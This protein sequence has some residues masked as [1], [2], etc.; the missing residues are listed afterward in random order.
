MPPVSQA[1]V[2]KQ[3]ASGR[4]EPLYLIL[5]ADE[6]A[7]VSLA[8]AFLDLVDE[9]LRAFN[10]DRLYGG[11]T[12]AAAV[13]DAA[14]TLP[15][16]VPRRVVLL[17]HAERL[18]ERLEPKKEK[19]KEKERGATS[20]DRDT[21]EAYVKAPVDTACL[22][23]VAAALDGRRSLTKLLLSRMAVVACEGP[24]DAQEAERWVRDRVSQQGL[25]I[26]ARAARLVAARVGPD[27]GRLRSDVDRLVLYAFDKKAITSEDVLEVVGAPTLQDD[28]G[29]TNAIERGAAADAL[30]ELVLLMDSGAVPY[31]ILGQLAWFVRTKV[32]ARKVEA[33]VEAVFRTDL[34]IKTS[35][36]DPRVLLE[37]LVVE[38]CG[39]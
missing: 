15:M 33:A 14:M 16:M 2:R 31:M 9:G 7:K 26:D 22:V 4:V 19:E 12:T 34:A 37:R 25:T 10:A 13:V 38:L 36:G 18:L 21:L 5:G 6:V 32:P 8:G 30:R 1:D 20:K 29:V 11:D 35:A 28:W 17:M 27:I 23:M 39:R 3:I 24:A